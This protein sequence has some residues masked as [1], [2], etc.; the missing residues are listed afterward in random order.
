MRHFITVD[1]DTSGHRNTN[2]NLEYLS[3]TLIIRKYLFLLFDGSGPLKS[4]FMLSN[5]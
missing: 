4:M 5:G 1:V 3:T 2:G